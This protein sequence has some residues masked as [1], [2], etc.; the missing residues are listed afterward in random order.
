M[1]T[2]SLF[3][4]YQQEMDFDLVAGVQLFIYKM[5]FIINCF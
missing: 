4:L 2:L 3:F 1:L 5:Y